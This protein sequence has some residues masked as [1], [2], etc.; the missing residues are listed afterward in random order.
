MKLFVVEFGYVIPVHRLESSQ[1][2]EVV[3]P[4]DYVWVI[5]LPIF[6]KIVPEPTSKQIRQSER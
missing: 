4:T 6:L 1:V 2:K 5:F 3:L